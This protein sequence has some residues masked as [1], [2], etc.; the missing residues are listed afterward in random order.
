[1]EHDQG[2]S[3]DPRPEK[4][5]QSDDAEGAGGG[6]AGHQSVAVADQ[7]KNSRDE[8]EVVVDSLSR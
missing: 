8:D 6:T 2:E 3:G 1:M 4:D 7:Q 5:Q